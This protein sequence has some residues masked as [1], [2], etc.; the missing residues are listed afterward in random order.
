[1][2]SCHTINKTYCSQDD[3]NCFVYHT[4][5]TY[6]DKCLIVLGRLVATRSPPQVGR[7]S[8]LYRHSFIRNWAFP[9]LFLFSSFQYCS[10]P[11]TYKIYRQLDSNRGSLVLEATTL[12]TEPQPLRILL[13]ILLL[14]TIILFTETDVKQKLLSEKIHSVGT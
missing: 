2:I 11:R 8:I 6:I 13:I 12:P 14:P 3:F 1:M 7:Q 9:S 10:I 5:V 4:P